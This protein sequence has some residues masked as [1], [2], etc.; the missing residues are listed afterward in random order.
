MSE[1]KLTWQLDTTTD[2]V[3]VSL[4]GVLNRHTLLP[5]WQQRQQ[6]VLANN[7]ECQHCQNIVWDLEAISHID[8]AGFALLTEL[9]RLNPVE[10]V[11]LINVP[12]QCLNLAALFSLKEWLAKY[13]NK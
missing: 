5:L 1:I 2:N 4:V 13:I 11:K 7:V 3:V 8:S 12:A 9:L 10:Q 6:F